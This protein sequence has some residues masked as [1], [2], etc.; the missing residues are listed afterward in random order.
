MVFKKLKLASEQKV[1]IVGLYNYRKVILNGLLPQHLQLETKQSLGSV[2][3][4][5]SVT[6]SR[7]I[8]SDISLT[9]IK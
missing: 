8:N 7:K 1:T 3:S 2:S 9:K 5:F 6:H 4:T